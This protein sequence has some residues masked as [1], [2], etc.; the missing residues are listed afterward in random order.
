MSPSLREIIVILVVYLL[1]AGCAGGSPGAGQGVDSS[2]MRVGLTA[3]YPP[4]AEKV[5]GELQGLEI[6]LA[7]EIGK[8][9]S[10]RVVF[11]EI[12]W[13][14]LIASLYEG[15]IDV[16]MSG[17]SVTDARRQQVAFSE[18]YMRIGQMAIIRVQDLRKLGSVSALLAASVDVGFEEGTT[19]GDFVKA[20]MSN[21]RPTGLASVEQG[22][23]ALRSRIIDV[24]VHDAPTAWR[25]GSDPAYQDLIGLYW[26]LTEEYLAWAVRKSD[27]SLLQALN[28][29]IAAMRSDGRLVQLT[30]RWIKV[31][32]EVK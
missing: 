5:N 27:V 15:E 13:E 30:R 12:P 14:R 19:G 11:V 2:V 22:V 9:L 3:N 26:P 24:F 8:D 29:E 16:I 32:V 20:N 23:A 31:K 4:L 6:D 28:G 18:P 1:L 21:A 10:K 25:I 17:M 7:R